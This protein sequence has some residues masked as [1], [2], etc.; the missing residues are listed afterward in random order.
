MG[1]WRGETCL[2]LGIW[3]RIQAGGQV[4]LRRGQPCDA[5]GLAAGRR[6]CR[7]ERWAGRSQGGGGQRQG[8]GRRGRGR[9][10][11]RETS[12]V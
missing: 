1:R 11:G 9:E 10:A 8:R 4:S 6:H 7:R 3:S 5:W 2:A 12:F